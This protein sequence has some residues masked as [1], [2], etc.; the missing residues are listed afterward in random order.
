MYQSHGEQS[1]AA[2]L[3]LRDEL[4]AS[5]G[6]LAAASTATAG[7]YAG[8]DPT[9]TVR[10]VLDEAGQPA[11]VE[12]ASE[13]RS[14]VGSDGLADGVR[15]A[16]QAAVGA[17]VTAWSEAVETSSPP[18]PPAG[19]RQPSPVDLPSDAEPGDLL[20][21]RV[22]S[23]LSGLMSLLAD[24]EAALDQVQRLTVGAG[25]ATAQGRSADREVTVTISAGELIELQAD[26]RWLAGA[27]ATAVG[28]AIRAALVDAHRSLSQ[29]EAVPQP[30]ALGELGTLTTDPVALLR[31]VGLLRD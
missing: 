7:A 18:A 4:L 28:R 13:W 1:L 17:R 27:S 12:L 24:A 8:E 25:P 22:Q 16:W 29:S 15:Q 19:H 11:D 2:V 5:A 9:G 21:Y 30:A 20:G 23:N 3:R 6:Q 14:A 31:T 10:I 26:P